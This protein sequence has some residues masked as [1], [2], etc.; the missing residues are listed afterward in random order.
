[1]S[2]S[3]KFLVRK[4]SSLIRLRLSLESFLFDF[5]LYLFKNQS[6]F[7]AWYGVSIVSNVAFLFS[8]LM[9]VPIPKASMSFL[10]PR[11]NKSYQINLIFNIFNFKIEMGSNISVVDPIEL[12]IL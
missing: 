8:E 1:M 7:F 12:F 11:L 4:G 5:L 10:L 9:F 2:I 3:G 6:Y